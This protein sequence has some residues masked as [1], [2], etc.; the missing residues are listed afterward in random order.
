MT[1]RATRR[2]SGALA[3]LLATRRDVAVRATI[4]GLV[5]ITAFVVAG[6]PRRLD[7]MAD[8]GLQAA[9]AGAGQTNRG[10]QL[11]TLDRIEPGGGDQP[12]AN[13][14]ERGRR[15][16]HRVPARLRS[17][18]SLADVVVDSARH[19]LSSLPG[20]R[21]VPYARFLT[22]RS[23]H[24]AAARI[25]YVQGRRPA[26]TP[27]TVTVRNN[28]GVQVAAPVVEVALSRDNARQLDL[29]AG[30]SAVLSP[31]NT[32]AVT[33]A[34]TTDASVDSH[35][36]TPLV[37]RVV[38]VFELVDPADP[39]WTATGLPRAVEEEQGEKLLVRGFALFEPAGYADVRAAMP[40]LVMHYTWRYALDSASVD[41]G[42]V[43]SL[44]QDVAELG[45]TTPSSGDAF[46]GR[47]TSRTG[48]LPLLDRVQ[49]EQSFARSVLAVVL[50][51]LLGVALALLTLVALL[52]AEGR[53]DVIALIRG[54]GGS[55]GQV[56]AAHLVEATV[57]CG[58]AALAGAAAAIA[59]VHGR[60]GGGIG[61]AV[62]L[63]L[64]FASCAV[65]LVTAAVLPHARRDVRTVGRDEVAAGG[66]SPRR[67]VLEG[68]VVVIALAGVLM[69]RRRGLIGASST[70]AA[71]GFDVYLA[72]VPLLLGLAAG[73]LTLRAYSGPVRLLSRIAAR[74]PGAVGFLG[75][76]RA[77]RGP[78]ATAVPLLVLLLSIAV[79]TFAS[80][81]S[82]TVTT[83]QQRAVWRDVGA[84]YRIDAPR[85]TALPSRFDVSDVPGVETT[86][87][88]Y[89]DSRAAVGRPGSDQSI[90]L[91]AIDAPAYLAVVNGTPAA[92]ELPRSFIEGRPDIQARLP[93]VVSA[94][95][96]GAQ[97]LGDGA[98]VT[99]TVAGS[100]VRAVV[101]DTVAHF[102]GVAAGRPF[103]VAPL[104][105]LAARVPTATTRLYVRGRD[106]AGPSLNAAVRTRS[107]DA[108]VAS[109][110]AQYAAAARTPTVSGV[111]GT[112]TVAVVLAALYAALGIIVGMILTARSRAQDLAHLRTLGLADRQATG[113]VLAEFGPMVAAATLLGY[114]L[115]LGTATVVTPRLG[116]GR[117][118]G[119]LEQ[120]TPAV[121]ARALA[122]VAG[123][124]VFDVIVAVGAAG[125]I[126]RRT[127]ISSTLRAGQR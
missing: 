91:L 81:V 36:E 35:V 97:R 114:A 109:R 34:S 53:R 115:G 67:L 74:R 41:G 126:S 86:A 8:R 92:V 40:A 51:G 119:S 105:A 17:A 54:R 71:A 28:N 39:Y 84:D 12:L 21:S 73:L 90:V 108:V 59:L 11:E 58:P 3:V 15:D 75:L 29:R 63:A 96:A 127:D 112:F 42:D 26:R 80:V 87:R 72:A 79:A 68:L 18:L 124:L 64:G 121:D 43:T 78:A 120:I 94:D 4:V 102:P 111:V 7:R 50:I 116:L 104:T 31:D 24:G 22:L 13:V 113:I 20:R 1:A 69:L 85:L 14:D 76:S 48:L 25:R 45:A 122:A 56:A 61:A 44:R 38:G 117:I 125:A 107:P 52:A 60:A 33:R 101:A 110:S 2:L 89:V 70:H 100:Q 47:T 57:L 16:L 103:A 10:V 95:L 5:A 106:Q 118:T 123:A 65:L 49:G 30:E 88:A 6:A 98:P 9:F 19:E 27:D 55:P 46:V 37:V 99:L 93:V 32:E 77:A 82:H 23:Q 66:L 62:L 83:S